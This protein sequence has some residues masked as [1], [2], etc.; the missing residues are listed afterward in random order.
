MRPTVVITLAVCLSIAGPA[1]AYASSSAGDADQAGVRLVVDRSVLNFAVTSQNQK[2]P[3]QTLRVT[4]TGAPAGQPCWTVTRS[5]DG[6]QVYSS[7]GSGS[8][9][10]FLQDL[11][12]SQIQGELQS[13][14]TISSTAE[15]SPQ[16]V[17]VWF[18]ALASS[19]RP[20]GFVDTPAENATISGSVGF[21]GW[22]ID[23]VG[24]TRVTLCRNAAAG[25]NAPVDGRCG[26]AAQFYVGDAVLIDDARPDVAAAFPNSPFHYRAG[27]G[28]LV[29]TNML[30]NQGNGTF[31]FSMRAFDVEG[32]FTLLGNRTVVVDNANAI[33]PFGAIDTPGQGEVIAGAA[34]NNFG[35]ALAKP[36]KS[37]PGASSINVFVDGVDLGNPS[38]GFPRGDVE[39][40]FPCPAYTNSCPPGPF[41]VKTINTTTYANGVHTIAWGVFDSAGVP[42][43]IGSRFFTIFNTGTTQQARAGIDLGRAIGELAALKPADDPARVRRGFARAAPLTEVPAGPRDVRAIWHRELDRV[44]LHLG[45][46]R[47][48]TYAGY[49]ILDGRLG[50]LPIGAT[51]DGHTGVFSW[52]PGVGYLGAYEFL[53]VRTTDDG[54]RERVPVKI[55]LE[56]RDY[57]RRPVQPPSPAFRTLFRAN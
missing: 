4:V 13:T 42:S 14:L 31:V 26:N 43:G 39:A 34:Y 2:T 3:P 54:R 36:G 27:W 10:V 28:F 50:L 8:F 41:G 56:P 47:T 33:E 32:G 46:T 20:A 38:Y 30:P 9:E 25:E 48:A 44:E 15:N 40:L 35:W 12:Y 29:L 51:L 1:R 37:I 19:N 45:A 11:D 24:V 52:Q 6:A 53:F 21:T 22:A 18:R 49:Q 17:Q 57:S 16:Q 55:V 23:D 5:S 7:C